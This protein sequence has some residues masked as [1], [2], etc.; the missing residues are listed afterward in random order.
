MD[1]PNESSSEDEEAFDYY[2]KNKKRKTWWRH[3]KK[4]IIY[5]VY[6]LSISI[7]FANQIF[8]IQLLFEKS[9]FDF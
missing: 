2:V 7:D 3:F 4:N 9:S 5:K 1:I 8:K 6:I